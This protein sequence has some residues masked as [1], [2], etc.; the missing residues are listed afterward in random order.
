MDELQAIRSFREDVP[1]SDSEA[2]G[3]ARQELIARIAAAPRSRRW[4]R[5]AVVVAALALA[6]VTAASALALYDFIAGEP[7][8]VAV[9]ERL[10]EEGTAERIAPFFT[11]KPSVI[12]ESAHGVAAIETSAGR[13][14]LWASTPEGGPICYLVEFEALTRASGIP[15][16][17]AKCGTRLSRYVPIVADLS[18]P[19]VDGTE[20]AIV[21][22]WAHETVTSV[23]LRSPEG[24][25]WELPLSERFFMAELPADRVPKEF[26]RE[27]THVVI[28]RDRRGAELDRWPVA[29]RPD[30]LFFNPKL[31]GPRR[32]VIDTTDSRGRPMRL[33]F[34]PIEGA[35]TCVELKTRGGTSVGCGQKL[36][37]EEGVQVHPALRES[38]VFVW[39]SVGPEVMKLELHHQDGY[40]IELP[41]AERFVLHDIPR[42][43]FEEGKRPV[44]L[45]AR[46]RDGG[47]VARE[48]ISQR[49]FAMQTENGQGDAVDPSPGRRGRN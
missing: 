45:V 25:E 23:V 12:A 39:G 14:I 49:L 48:K 20:L 47:E 6:A 7:A 18:R 41:I 28:A 8:P 17:D 44:L 9:A 21:V 19:I 27:K 29:G 11:G 36:W 24:D 30:L 38:M 42:A 10:V 40:V 13:A 32:T 15:R 2:R 33:S 46:G 16:G 31:A 43:R 37:V 35:D 34:V 3:V 1:A 22:G 5:L 4:P 26:R